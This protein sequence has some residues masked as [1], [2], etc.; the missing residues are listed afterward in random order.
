[1]RVPTLFALLSLAAISA[2]QSNA[3]QGP[4]E[5]RNLRSLSVPFF[6][7]DPRPDVLGK[8]ERTLSVGFT[9]A[10]DMRILPGMEE[11]YEID[12]LLFRYRISV[13]KKMDLTFDLPLLSR[14]GGFMDP[15]VW[16][17]HK[18]IL[19][20]F[21]SDRD[22]VPFGR[23]V[24]DVPGGSYGSA[25]GI[26]DISASLSRQFTPRLL[27]T[28]G[29]KAPTGN[30]GQ[31]LGSGNID[32]AVAVQYHAPLGP[33]FS[34]YLRAGVVAQGQSTELDSTRGLVD[35]EAVVFIW[36]PNSRD[37]WLAQWQGESSAT[38]TGIA[39]SDA[40]HR[41]ISFG[42]HRRLSENHGLEL[43]FSEDKDFFNAPKG[44]TGTAPDFTAGVR[45]TIKL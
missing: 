16:D 36:H 7:L 43:F 6:R 37:A 11:D 27:G 17:W 31:I 15:L 40:P 32:G 13:G 24:V 44:L 2:A 1:M 18:Y 45:L 8:G 34:T 9:A 12:R 38:V 22:G 35:Q 3:D 28:V 10:N 39:G 30:A 19:G 20:G 25:V 21:R 4:L 5:I 23:S 33:W 26:G 14:G 29:I 41:Q 42:Y